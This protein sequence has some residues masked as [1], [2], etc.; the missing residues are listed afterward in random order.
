LFL[1]FLGG[2]WRLGVDVPHGWLVPMLLLAALV[3]VPL[4]A[5]WPSPFTLGW[6]PFTLLF[7]A[8]ILVVVGFFWGLKTGPPFRWWL[9]PTTLLGLP[10]ALIPVLLILLAAWLILCLDIGAAAAA[11]PRKDQHGRRRGFETPQFNPFRVGL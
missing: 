6:S 4:R 10:I 8:G 7:I 5:E 11:A 3:L 2:F 1:I 9:W